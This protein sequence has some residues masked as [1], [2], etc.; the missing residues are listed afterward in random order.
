MATPTPVLTLIF[1]E[2]ERVIGVVHYDGE[3]MTGSIACM[4]LVKNRM[5]RNNM[6][7]AEA[8]KDLD[9]WSNGYLRTRLKE[10]A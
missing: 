10:T 5:R 3:G 2:G 7:A 1:E 4:T 8:I 9:G 6:T